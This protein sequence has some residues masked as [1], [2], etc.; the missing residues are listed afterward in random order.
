MLKKTL[1]KKIKKIVFFFCFVYFEL[2]KASKQFI[3]FDFTKFI[4][5]S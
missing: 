2:L 3:T 5:K 1:T 4:A